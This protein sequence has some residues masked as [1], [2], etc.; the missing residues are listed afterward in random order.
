MCMMIMIQG[1]I[2]VLGK[3]LTTTWPCAHTFLQDQTFNETIFFP[4][5]RVGEAAAAS[6]GE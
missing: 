4:L 6:P 3:K 1:A 2:K 5:K